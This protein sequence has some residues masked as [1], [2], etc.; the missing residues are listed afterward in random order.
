MNNTAF[1]IALTNSR[2]SA[3]RRLTRFTLQELYELSTDVYD[4]LLRRQYSNQGLLPTQRL[5]CIL[6]WIAVFL[7]LREDFQPQR[8]QSRAKLAAVPLSH[9]EDLCNDIHR[10]LSR[11]YPEFLDDVC[12]IYSRL[13]H[14]SS[15]LSLLQPS[16]A[17]NE[18]ESDDFLANYQ[19]PSA[20]TSRAQR[21]PL[22]VVDYQQVLKAHFDEFS[23]LLIIYGLYSL[24]VVICPTDESLGSREHEAKHNEVH[25]PQQTDSTHPQPVSRTL[26][27][28]IRRTYA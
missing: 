22:P 9:F 7:P 8:N 26:D 3:R 24:D 10:E 17:S 16:V 20:L 4:E 12:Y 1:R 23:I 5:K 15:T 13:E 18:Y 27:R 28:C 14:H 11:R 19:F 6:T 21:N 25:R 2:S